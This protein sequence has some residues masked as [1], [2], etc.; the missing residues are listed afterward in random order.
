VFLDWSKFPYVEQVGTFG[1]LPN[2]AHYTRIQFQ[3]LRFAYNVL[4][5]HGHSRN[6]LSGVVTIA[7]D[8]TVDAMQMGSRVQK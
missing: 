2:G 4:S 1:N 8:G 3:D 7:P 5:M 6:P